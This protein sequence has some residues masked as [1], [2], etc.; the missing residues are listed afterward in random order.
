MIYIDKQKYSKEGIQITSEY[1]QNCCKDSATGR[2]VNVCYDKRDGYGHSLCRAD[3]GVY[4]KRMIEV[5][6]KSQNRYCCY[7]LRKLKAE[8]KEKDLEKTSIEHIIP[9]GYTET[10]KENLEEYQK[11]PNLDDRNVVLRDDFEKKSPQTIPPY[12]HNVAYFNLVAS[13]FGNFPDTVHGNKA[14]CCNLVRK[15]KFAYPVFYH[16]DIQKYV[17][18]EPDGNIHPVGEKLYDE[19]KN[20][21]CATKLYARPLRDIRKLWYELRDVDYREIYTCQKEEYRHVLLSKY[22]TELNLEERRRFIEKYKKEYQWHTFMLYRKF[23]SIM[24]LQFPSIK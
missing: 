7:C 19:I 20:V 2:Y 11:A 17:S 24:R 13:C 22:L 16:H 18:Y 4:H 1:L 10:N 8:S 9:R 12:P 6:H 23:Y 5:L 3:K 21:I 15:E 14:T